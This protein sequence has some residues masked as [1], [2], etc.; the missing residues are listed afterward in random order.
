[1]SLKKNA[2]PK[3]Q[4][5]GDTLERL[6][7]LFQGREKVLNAFKGRIFPL[8]TIEGTGRAPLRLSFNSQKINSKLIISK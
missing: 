5:K 8:A 3:K 6:Y 4:R 2:K 1:M 7:A